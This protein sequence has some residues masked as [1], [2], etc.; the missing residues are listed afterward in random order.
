M[1]KIL[2]NGRRGAREREKVWWL[3][4]RCLRGGREERGGV[5]L[6]SMNYGVRSELER[7]G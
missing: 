1:K 7:D 5:N 6:L 4:L 3:L 2:R